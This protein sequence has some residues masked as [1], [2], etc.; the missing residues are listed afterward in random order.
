MCTCVDLGQKM[1]HGAEFGTTA[2]Q[3]TAPLKSPMISRWRSLRILYH[4]GVDIILSV[5]HANFARGPMTEAVPTK[6][7]VWPKLIFPILVL[8]IE[9][10]SAKF[11]LVLSVPNLLTLVYPS[12]T[13]HKRFHYKLHGIVNYFLICISLSFACVQSGFSVYSDHVTKCGPG[14][15]IGKTINILVWHVV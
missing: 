13:C 14:I 7:L 10:F 15:S 3:L 12:G 5:P 6:G 9:N 2:S 1:G 4:Y 11:P 8:S